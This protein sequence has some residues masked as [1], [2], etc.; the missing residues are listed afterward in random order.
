MSF[1]AAGAIVPLRFPLLGSK[2]CLPIFASWPI[3]HNSSDRG[4]KWATFDARDAT[5]CCDPRAE[6]QIG[7]GG[8]GNNPVRSACSQVIHRV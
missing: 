5:F 8:R 6:I 1:G 4:H 3:F 2:L 7:R